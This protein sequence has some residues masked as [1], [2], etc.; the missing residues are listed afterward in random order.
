MKYIIYTKETF[1]AE[2]IKLKNKLRK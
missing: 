2:T 1:K